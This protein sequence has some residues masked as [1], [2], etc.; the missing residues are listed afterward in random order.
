LNPD[1]EGVFGCVTLQFHGPV[2]D[3]C[4][5]VFRKR[6]PDQMRKDEA[7]IDRL[8]EKVM[9]LLGSMVTLCEGM[10]YIWH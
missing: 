6:T 7:V 2:N 9:G 3:E 4:T 8:L 5:V 1:P 10:T